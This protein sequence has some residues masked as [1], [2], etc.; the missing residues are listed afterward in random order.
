MVLAP[1][2]GQS[3]YSFVTKE[4]KERDY[5]NL[6]ILPFLLSRVVHNLVW[7]SVSRHRTAK[8]KNRIVDKTIEF[9]QVDRESNWYVFCFKYEVMFNV[10]F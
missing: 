5:T 10:C 6:M 8:G 9:E 7:I 1:W 2:I 3:C 4:G